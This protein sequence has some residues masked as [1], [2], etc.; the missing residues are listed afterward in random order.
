MGNNIRVHHFMS[1]CATEEDY[2]SLTLAEVRSRFGRRVH[3]EL[4]QWG[5]TIVPSGRLVLD[6]KLVKPKPR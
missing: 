6:L 1:L 4:I 3:D 2:E 5:E